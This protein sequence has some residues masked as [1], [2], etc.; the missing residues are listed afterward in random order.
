[1]K[2]DSEKL[3]KLGKEG[4]LTCRLHPYLPLKIYNYTPKVQ[5]E[6]H[7]TP[8][9]M[10]CRGLIVDLT[11][12]IVARP[13]PKFFNWSEYTGKLPDSDVVIEE[14]FDGSLGILYWDGSIP[15]I[16]TRGSFES[17]Q[18]IWA[19]RW[20]K[21]HFW[22]FGNLD[23]KATYLFEIIYPENRIVVDY[24][25]TRG[26]MLLAKIDT[27]TGQELLMEPTPFNLAEVY[28]AGALAN[29]DMAAI[30]ALNRKNE[31]GFVILWPDCGF[32]LK[33]KFD[34]YV[35][36]HRLITGVTA[37]SIWDLMRTGTSMDELLERVPD[38]FYNWVAKTRDELQNHYNFIL[39]KS[40][41]IAAYA[42]T[43]EN[44]KAQAEYLQR[45]AHPS[46]VFKM[47]DGKNPEE[48]IWRLIKPKAEKPFKIE[49]V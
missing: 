38:E 20:A 28:Y 16:A 31:E 42:R 24:G 9:T 43:L 41:Q 6:K 47:L 13:F 22:K 30:Q 15:C 3:D 34:E 29:I 36:L 44:R 14:K 2:I 32:R 23:K 18:A 7:W 10:M 39:E 8:E 37:R 48:Q 27:E 26:I 1:M 19:T 49:E 45:V 12:E 35:R 46:I 21:E 17:E 40:N 11:D 4:F 5:F 33:I 25:E